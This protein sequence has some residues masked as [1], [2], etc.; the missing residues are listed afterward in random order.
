MQIVKKSDFSMCIVTFTF[1]L[2][3]PSYK[4]LG[5]IITT[6]AAFEVSLLGKQNDL[7]FRSEK[8]LHLVGVLTVIM[9]FQGPHIYNKR[10]CK[11][12]LNESAIL[13]LLFLV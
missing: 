6:C 12:T 8:F 7:L 1:K 13:I 5:I 11:Q 2:F 4:Q 10:K 3:C 9:L